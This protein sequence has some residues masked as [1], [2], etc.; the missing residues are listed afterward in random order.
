MNPSAIMFWKH[1]L[2]NFPILKKNG[3]LV[4]TIKMTAIGVKTTMSTALENLR[5]L[6]QDLEKMLESAEST[7]FVIV[8]N[9]EEIKCHKILLMGRSDYF[10]T[11]VYNALMEGQTGRATVNMDPAT[12]RAVMKY[13]YTGTVNKITGVEMEKLFKA[14]HICM[15]T[16]LQKMCQDVLL[17]DVTLANAIQMMALGHLY[18]VVDLKEN[19]K[20]IFLEAGDEFLKQCDWKKELKEIPDLAVE[21][22]EAAMTK[23]RAV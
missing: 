6:S 22:V 18:D 3:D 15:L 23:N 4:L 14:A 11:L 13:V 8:C 2:Y 17:A 16:G 12:M 19:A 21:L 5:G 7:D 1:D 9:G 20:K 10:R